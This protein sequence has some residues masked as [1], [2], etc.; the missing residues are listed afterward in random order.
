M[1]NKKLT[2]LERIKLITDLAIVNKMSVAKV[3]DIYSKFV[4]NVYDNYIRNGGGVKSDSSG[5]ENQAFQLTG[6]FLN[7]LN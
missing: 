3:L 6:S 5:L 7:R 2:H 4:D 1:E